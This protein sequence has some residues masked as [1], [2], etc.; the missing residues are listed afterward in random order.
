MKTEIRFFYNWGALPRKSHSF[1]YLYLV[2]ES[3]REKE[4]QPVFAFSNKGGRVSISLS[5]SFTLSFL[6]SEYLL[7][8][9]SGYQ[10]FSFSGYLLFFFGTSSY[11]WSFFHFKCY[12]T[13]RCKILGST[14]SFVWKQI[15]FFCSLNTDLFLLTAIG[16]LKR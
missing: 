10:L 6:F 15:G 13:T 3:E 2:K 16:K 14:I 5:P 7:F 4:E 1:I 8:S 12:R 11:C 9:F